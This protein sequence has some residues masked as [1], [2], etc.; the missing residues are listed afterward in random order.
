MNKLFRL[1]FLSIFSIAIFISCSDDPSSVGANL[2]PDGDKITFHE[3][4]SQKQPIKYSSD[5]FY[6]KNTLG[7]A[8]KLLLGK[9]S[10]SQSSFLLRFIPVF[11]DSLL[12]YLKDGNLKINSTWIEMFPAYKMGDSTQNFNFSIHQLRSD[13]SP[14]GFNIDSLKAASFQYD[15]KDVSGAKTFTDTL[16]T[17]K[18][19]PNVVKEWLLY[20]K[21]NTLAKNYGLI[22]KPTS[23]TNRYLGFY[24]VSV[25]TE[26]RQPVLFIEYE[27]PGINKDTTYVSP[28]IDTHVVEGQLPGNSTD[29]VVQAGYAVRSYVYFDVSSI[30]KASAVNKAT[31]ELSINHNKT[32]DGTPSSDSIYVRVFKD[33][34]T[35]AYG[36]DSSSVLLLRREGDK[37][38]GDLTWM[39]QRWI[40][41]G[42]NQ[43]F[44][45]SLADEVNA[46]S[47]IV[48]YGPK[49]S[50]VA[51]RPKIKIVYFQKK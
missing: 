27:R 47:R 39:V 24:A 30:E 49:D 3:F 11:S 12:T 21:D 17:V 32:F 45:L 42:G 31:F 2:I 40:T 23:N 10:Y 25:F 14:V 51:L 28:Y 48:F 6:K 15:Q 7:A 38:I 19:D 8:E 36:S 20:Q 35:K 44:E 9:N 41:Q 18:M 4:D 13:W 43:G 46:A 37:F 22:F 16:V 50:N 33:S 26:A 34:T 29:L 5:V 1:I